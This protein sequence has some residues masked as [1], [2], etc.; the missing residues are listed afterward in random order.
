M[1][2]FR[3]VSLTRDLRHGPRDI[4]HHQSR[5]EHHKLTYYPH[6]TAPLHLLIE[7]N[8]TNSTLQI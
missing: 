4:V 7:G 3:M 2:D 8:F 6:S 1:E 5:L